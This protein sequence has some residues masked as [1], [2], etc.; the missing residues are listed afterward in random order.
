MPQVFVRPNQYEPGRAHVVIYN[1]NGQSSVSVN[2]ANVLKPG[3]H[4]EVRNVQDLFGTP[5]LSGTYLGGSVSIPMAGVTPPVPIGGSPRAPIRTGPAFDVFLV[6][7]SG[8]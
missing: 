3:A 4:Y 7:S 6:T 2:L 5:V 1:W 8:P